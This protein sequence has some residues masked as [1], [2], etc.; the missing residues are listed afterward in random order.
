MR[1]RTDAGGWATF[2]GLPQ[3]YEA[4]LHVADLRFAQLGNPS[5]FPLAGASRTPDAAV[6]LKPAGVIN[7]RAVFAGAAH[8]P[9]ANVP[10]L[11]SM[12]GG[13]NH[14]AVTDSQGH[15]HVGQLAQGSYDVVANLGFTK[16]A[17]D[18]TAPALTGR[19]VQPGHPTNV[20]TMRLE[21][22]GLLTVRVTDIATGAPLSGIPITVA[23]PSNADGAGNFQSYSTNSVGVYRVHVPAGSQRV[24]TAVSGAQDSETVVIA[25]GESKTIYFKL[26]SQNSALLTGTVVD[27]AGKPVAGATVTVF[28][29]FG[30]D[31]VTSGVDGKFSFAQ[32][33]SDVNLA[34][35]KG[36]AA[37]HGLRLV[38]VT[39]KPI[40]VQLAPS[41]A[42]GAISG[43]VVDTVGAV[44]PR[45][46]V[47]L[48]LWA[49]S[50]GANFI[51]AQTDDAGRYRFNDCFSSVR[52]SV[53]AENPGY[54]YA[55]S[56]DATLKP[57]E[58]RI[59]PPIKLVRADSFVAGH[60]LDPGGK[61]YPGATI[62]YNYVTGATTQTD[63]QGYFRL[64]GV[65]GGK[66][67]LMVDVARS[68]ILN[69]GY[70]ALAGHGD[71][72]ISLES[73]PRRE[74]QG[75]YY[76]ARLMPGAKPFPFH[77]TDL[78]GKS[79]SLNNY[80]GKVLVLDFWATWCGPC[81]GE[82]PNVIATY[83]A[84]HKNGLE[85]V[86][87]SLDTDKARLLNYIKA[88]DVPYPQLY[89]GKQFGESVAKAYGVQA[90]PFCLVIGR[91]GRIV[92]ANVRGLALESAVS[93]A[94]A[95]R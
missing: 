25:D 53:M 46:S 68:G 29:D 4:R 57:A 38:H 10:I 17:A 89:D 95:A 37:T 36:T 31:A 50:S 49:G 14:Q 16:L 62:T 66:L 81:V 40:T 58:A 64:N 83:N 75:G 54:T 87:V 13:D 72:V 65:P 63:A 93:A 22:G 84:L 9:A 43:R 78:S 70:D 82:M 51:K 23:G 28:Q 21:H 19:Y 55:Y 90:I 79:I 7:G 45:A 12:Q 20:G 41:A 1:R 71:N 15:F 44:M 48:V 33:M 30:D 32:P 39:A 88:N 5:D 2:T 34:A 77:A 86:G 67:R 60:V 80:K 91:N 92:A 94:L 26:T 6:T 47:T 11:V 76:D 69:T 35:Q 18:W 42:S 24:Y 3:H 27:S 59:F 52:Y 8:R 61:P 56:D 73:E 74:Q 85:V